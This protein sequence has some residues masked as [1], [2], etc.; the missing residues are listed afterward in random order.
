MKI[1]ISI[2]LLFSLTACA[3][4]AHLYPANDA[5]A[6][7]GVLEA[8]YVAWGTGHVDLTIKTPDE[9]LKGEASLVRGA[10]V[11]FGSIFGHVYGMATMPGGSPGTASAFGDKGSYGQCEYYNDNWSGHGY[12]ACKIS[13]A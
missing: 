5:A 11:G 6:E 9:T 3:T 4:T 10:S 1:I 7:E 12:G 2:I 13:K 8:P